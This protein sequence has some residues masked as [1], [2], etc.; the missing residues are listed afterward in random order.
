[1]RTFP[2]LSLLSLL[3]A[4]SMDAAAQPAAQPADAIEEADTPRA[5]R[6]EIRTLERDMFELFNELNS[7]DEFDVTCDYHTPTG[8]KV[9]LW[10][11]EPAFIRI[12]ESAEYMQMKDNAAATGGGLRGLGYL[13]RRGDDV[14]F[15]QR[16]KAAQMQEEMR[17]L[18]L[19]HPEL[20]T[21]IVALHARRLQLAEMEGA[22][23]E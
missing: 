10:Q 9:P 18:A 23:Q 17:A 19:A 1:M 5:L 11:C 16:E 15:M 7:N 13:P 4:A 2:R 20:A 6:A 8:S 3:F 22:S 14:A 21:A 12:A